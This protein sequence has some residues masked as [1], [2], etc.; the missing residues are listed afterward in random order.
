MDELNLPLGEV[1]ECG[2]RVD[3]LQREERFAQALANYDCE[4]VGK[5]EA[6]LGR[7]GSQ[8]GCEFNSALQ[9]N[10]P[11]TFFLTASSFDANNDR[12]RA[13]LLECANR[14]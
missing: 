11:R 10:S 5:L 2:A 7:V 1:K 4:T 3:M 14:D 8:A 6:E 12:P 13:K 9:S